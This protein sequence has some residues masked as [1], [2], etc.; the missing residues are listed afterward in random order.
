M[1]ADQE[2]FWLGL[3]RKVHGE[4]GHDR[5]Q[6][7]GPGMSVEPLRTLH[8]RS[9]FKTKLDYASEMCRHR[10]TSAGTAGGAG[11]GSRPRPSRAMQLREVTS[12]WRK[13]PACQPPGRG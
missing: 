5:P 13:E 4:S 8:S 12:W 6:D 3:H 7:A 2:R 11:P 9:S 10:G 1:V